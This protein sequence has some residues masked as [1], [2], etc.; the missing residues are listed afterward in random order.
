ME[1][2]RSWETL[3]QHALEIL[4]AG[5]SRNAQGFGQWSFGGGTALM[6]DHR[7][8][9]SKDVD[10]FVPDPQCLGYLSPRL[11]DVAE[12]KTGAY[13]EQSGYVKL[14][15]PEGEVDFIVSGPLTL[16]PY[17]SRKVLGRIVLVE[18]PQEIL[19]KKLRYRAASLKARD[20]FDLA[21]VLERS[22][23]VAHAIRAIYADKRA[24]IRE[25]L[26]SS[27]V[28]LRE[29]FAALDVWEYERSYDECLAIVRS[30]LDAD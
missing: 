15:F 17:Q 9:V 7:H 27:D 2:T 19:A 13:D 14:Y 23:D 8:R 5:R 12:A 20:L 29:D 18:T 30:C 21:C 3:F 6:L 10:I 24:L 26:R 25:R 1:R 11:N 28:A 22:A 16:N 4:D